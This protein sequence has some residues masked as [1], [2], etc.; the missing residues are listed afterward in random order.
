MLTLA[1]AFKKQNKKTPPITL[2]DRGGDG[3]TSPATV[4]MLERSPYGW[5]YVQRLF[6]LAVLH[7]I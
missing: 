5:V 6:V 1:P 2:N 4:K 7:K 3:R